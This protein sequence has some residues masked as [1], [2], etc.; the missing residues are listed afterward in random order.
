MSQ[1]DCKLEITLILMSVKKVDE[2]GE[3]WRRSVADL[4]EVP[5]Y[6]GQKKK[7]QNNEK[8]QKEEKPAGQALFA[9]VCLSIYSGKN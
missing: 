1:L 5:P 6:F 2:K 3:G 9:N 4:G 8:T 7:Q